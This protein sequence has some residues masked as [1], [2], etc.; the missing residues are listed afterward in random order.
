MANSALLSTIQHLGGT[1]TLA[2]LSGAVLLVGG[3]FLL[4]GIYTRWAAIT[5]LL[6]LIPITVSVQLGNGLMHGPLW[7]NIALAGG[8]IFF[9]INHSE[10]FFATPA[11]T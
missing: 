8:L 7:K 6:V 2:L 5:L 3:I 1:H 9:I 11:T 4:T 10:R